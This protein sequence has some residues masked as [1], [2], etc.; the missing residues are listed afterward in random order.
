MSFWR[1]GV[2]RF[3]LVR[4]C[5]DSGN[6]K[7]HHDVEEYASHRSQPT[8][9]RRNQGWGRRGD[10][11][12]Y[13]YYGRN[14]RT[15]LLLELEVKLGSGCL[16]ASLAKQRP[17]PGVGQAWHVSGPSGS[18]LDWNVMPHA[19]NTP[20]TRAWLHISTWADLPA[21]ALTRGR[22]AWHHTRSAR[23]ASTTSATSTRIK[24]DRA[25]P[26]L[27]DEP[28][29]KISTGTPQ[30]V[31]PHIFPVLATLHPCQ[32]TAQRGGIIGIIGWKL[33]A[34]WLAAGLVGQLKQSP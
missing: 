19:R 1:D 28:M 10:V 9:R 7:R 27:H 24:R 33:V 14:G 32:K 8:G 3:Q 23:S 20:A 21:N 26:R 2:Q 29:T 34:S 25:C 18:N 15:C 4:R 5:E 6:G 11:S 31:A 16:P 22:V 30:D 12:L 17:V 13:G